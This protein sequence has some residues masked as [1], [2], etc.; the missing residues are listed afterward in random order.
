LLA[1]ESWSPQ[2]LGP[3]ESILQIQQ[4]NTDLWKFFT[5]FAMENLG[6]S[7]NF[8]KFPREIFENHH[9]FIGKSTN[10]TA[11]FNSYAAAG[12][13]ARGWILWQDR[14]RAIDRNLGQLIL[15]TM[16]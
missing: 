4:I 15:E 8:I 1:E 16:L 6:R 14:S 3:K 13:D 7:P 2:W 9:F 5:W 10:D 11:M 12:C